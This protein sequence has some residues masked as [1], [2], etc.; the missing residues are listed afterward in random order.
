MAEPVYEHQSP[1]FAVGAQFD[2]F[3]ELKH[4]C[5]RAALHDVYEFDTV[6]VFP[7]SQ[8][9]IDGKQVDSDRYRI[10][11]KNTECEWFLYA[12]SLDGTVVWEVRTTV[13][14]HTCHGINH[15]G[16]CNIDEEFVSHEILPKLRMDNSFTPKSIQNHFQDQ[17]G[18]KI[19]YSKAYRA[20][21]RALNIIN[22]SHEEAYGQLPKYCEEIMRSNPGSTVKL[23]L[24]AETNQF[25]RLFVCFGTSAMG[26]AHCRPLL[27][28]DGTHL[29]HKY[30]G[31]FNG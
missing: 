27:G 14:V 20:K 4:A 6:H 1:R 18:V 19:S 11:C 25:K 13:Q 26:L 7:S 24:D 17:Y 21:E 22:G 30:Q 23:E 9:Q 16:H 3:I 28:L 12:V 15:N 5:I 29:K 8:H 10:R 31:T 2:S